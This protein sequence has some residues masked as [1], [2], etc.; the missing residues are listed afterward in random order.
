MKDIT[1]LYVHINADGDYV[2]PKAPEYMEISM[3]QTRKFHN[4]RIV[5]IG[6]NKEPW[7]DDMDVEH[8]DQMILARD[9]IPEFFRICWESRP[10][11]TNFWY[12]TMGRMQFINA[13][14]QK[15]GLENTLY[16]ENDNLIYHNTEKLEP[17]FNNKVRYTRVSRLECSPGIMLMPSPEISNRFFENFTKNIEL[18]RNERLTDMTILSHMAHDPEV[19]QLPSLPTATN[20]TLFDGASYGQYLGGTNNGHPKGFTD[21]HHYVGGQI[22]CGNI[23]VPEQLPPIVVD[24]REH[25]L[26]NLHIHSKQ[27]K[28]FVV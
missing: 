3:R 21:D 24:E 7:F 11:E 25:P 5:Y 20:D 6:A 13:A 16:L 23:R 26:Y 8:I 27:L 22:R 15:L 2:S 4:G 18:L 12:V 19:E 10:N 9:C 28:D 1:V 17:F 14:I